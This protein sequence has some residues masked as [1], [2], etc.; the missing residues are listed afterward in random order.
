MAGLRKADQKVGTAYFEFEAVGEKKSDSVFLDLD[1]FDRIESIIRRHI[2]GFDYVGSNAPP[3]PS[4]QAL[5][6]E[7]RAQRE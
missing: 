6:S 1:D 5:A 7:L 4:W 3:T 2:S